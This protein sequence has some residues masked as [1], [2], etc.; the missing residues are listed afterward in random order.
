MSPFTAT[1]TTQLNAGI[2]ILR[3]ITGVIFAAHGAQKLFVFGLDGVAAG[4]AQMGVP[5][6]SIAGPSVAFLELIGGIA[7]VLG[8]LTRP[9]AAALAFVMLGAIIF[10]HWSAGFF[11]PNGFEFVLAL[12]A[13]ATA[14]AIV[15]AGRYSLDALIARRASSSLLS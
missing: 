2:G 10:A 7:I 8:L 3:V 5:L 9:V 6:A 1:S 14:L 11:M 12:F 13:T 4:F 15:G